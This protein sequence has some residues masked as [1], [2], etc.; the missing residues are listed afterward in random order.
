MAKKLPEYIKET[1]DGYEITLSK[2]LDVMGSKVNV[3]TMREP[4]VADQETTSTMEGSDATR[5]IHEFANLCGVTPDDLRKMGLR[6]YNRLK[7]AYLAFI[8]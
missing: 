5:E 4:L 3:V 1:G 7:T 6:D 2:P 8:F